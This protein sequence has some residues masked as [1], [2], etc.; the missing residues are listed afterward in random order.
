VLLVRSFSVSRDVRRCHHSVLALPDTSNMRCI[1]FL[2]VFLFVSGRFR[3]LR[4][5]QWPL[6]T[7]AGYQFGKMEGET[8]LTPGDVQEY[9]VQLLVCIAAVYGPYIQKIGGGVLSN[10]SVEKSWRWLSHSG[11]FRHRKVALTAAPDGRTHPT[12][13]RYD[14]AQ[15]I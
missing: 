15:R 8:F 7:S 10:A 4:H 11:P 14:D 6:F 9:A 12:V 2:S 1:V 13:A 3:V 5:F